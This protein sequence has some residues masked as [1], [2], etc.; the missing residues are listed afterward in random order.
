MLVRPF[1]LDPTKANQFYFVSL[2][3]HFVLTVAVLAIQW[4]VYPGMSASVLPVR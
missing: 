2:S 1:G 4:P 3:C